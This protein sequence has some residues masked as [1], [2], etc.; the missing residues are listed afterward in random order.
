MEFSQLTNPHNQVPVILV[1]IL[2]IYTGKSLRS[3]S[4]PPEQLACPL[5]SMQG[6][7]G[8]LRIQAK[9]GNTDFLKER[10]SFMLLLC[11]TAYI[12]VYDLLPRLFLISFVAVK[13]IQ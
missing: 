6:C 12:A 2:M 10:R 4:W 1:E 8:I 11:F 7:Q 5:G 13:I 3:G 9:E